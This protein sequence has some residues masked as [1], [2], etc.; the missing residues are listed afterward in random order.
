MPAVTVSG[1]VVG[2]LV[3]TAPAPSAL[4]LADGEDTPHD[5]EDGPREVIFVQAPKVFLESR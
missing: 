4:V 1:G 5:G 2:D 3:P